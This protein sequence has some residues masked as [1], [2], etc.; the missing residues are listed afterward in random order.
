MQEKKLNSK[1]NKKIQ[2]NIQHKSN[3]MGP[4]TKKKIYSSEKS[5]KK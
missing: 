3:N 2:N 4:K 5:E 1:P